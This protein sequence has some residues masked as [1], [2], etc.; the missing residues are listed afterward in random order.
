MERALLE[1]LIGT[2]TDL[3]TDP[4]SIENGA[5]MNSRGH[6]RLM[7]ISLSMGGCDTGPA[8]V[9][10]EKAATSDQEIVNRSA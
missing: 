5:D 9:W 10:P 1:Q 2:R 7:M 6:L 3:G 8:D 4:I